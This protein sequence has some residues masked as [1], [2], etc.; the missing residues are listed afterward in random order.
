V[1]SPDR[2][3]RK[4]PSAKK[5][6]SQKNPAFRSTYMV[7][8]TVLVTLGF[9]DGRRFLHLLLEYFKGRIDAGKQSDQNQSLVCIP[10]GLFDNQEASNQSEKNEFIKKVLPTSSNLSFFSQVKTPQLGLANNST[11]TNT[12]KFIEK[13][14]G[15]A[16][17]LSL[18]SSY[19]KSQTYVISIC[20]S[21]IS[22]YE[23][24]KGELLFE[25]KEA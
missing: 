2:P 1:T 10:G 16:N 23:L 25:L 4:L 12:W 14:L 9:T 17:Y 6:D 21:K 11:A 5:Q 7:V 22:S 18:Y 8:R 3:G 13:R 15:C 20:Q 24:Q 19:V